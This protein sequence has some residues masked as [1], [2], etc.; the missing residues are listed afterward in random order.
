MHTVR[1]DGADAGI[2]GQPLVGECPVVF[3]SYS[4]DD[5]EWRRRFTVWSAAAALAF[6]VA[7]PAGDLAIVVNNIFPDCLIYGDT[8]PDLPT[9]PSNRQLRGL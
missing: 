1:P 5:A 6:K 4:R 8:P 7:G 3:V 2:S 9:L